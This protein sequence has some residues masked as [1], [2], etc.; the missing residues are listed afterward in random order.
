MSDSIKGLKPAPSV[1][2]T[3]QV[4]PTANINKV[5]PSAPITKAETTA[6]VQSSDLPQLDQVEQV[7]HARLS[8]LIDAVDRGEHTGEEAWEEALLL[9]LT[10]SLNVPRPVAISLLPRLRSLLDTDP[11]AGRALRERLKGP[12]Q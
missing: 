4:E 9:A 10:S 3:A 6:R 8:A 12:P 1:H 7:T 5:S 2:S 11:D